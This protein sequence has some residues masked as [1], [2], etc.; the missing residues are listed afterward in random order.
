MQAEHRSL[1][2]A[3]VGGV[4]G[5][6]VGVALQVALDT[7]MFGKRF[8]A[9]WFAVAIGVLTGLGVRQMNRHHMERS[10]LRGALAGIIALVA[11]VAS[12]FASREVMKRKEV[13]A[14]P[15]AVAAAA[16]KDSDAAGDADAAAAEPAAPVAPEANGLPPVGGIGRP[17]IGLAD[18]STLEF[19]FMALG[20]LVAYEL[21]RGI[22]HSK[23][24]AVP[25]ESPGEA[26]VATDPSN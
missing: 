1:T 24:G 17:K 18:N 2:P 12:S 16:A 6:L 11:I 7:G 9:P 10:Y 3:L 22:D 13:S 14:K 5:A 19:V 21:G 26:P 4:I 15:G 20:G 23:R 8:E 25:V